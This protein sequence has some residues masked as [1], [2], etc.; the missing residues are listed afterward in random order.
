MVVG[1][2]LRV[3]ASSVEEDQGQGHPCDVVEEVGGPWVVV[4]VA[5]EVVQ[6][7]AAAVAG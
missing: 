1:H 6:V 7:V 4:V 3:A 5:A 2:A